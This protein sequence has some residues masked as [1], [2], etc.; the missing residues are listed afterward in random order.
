[1][2][3]YLQINH[4]MNDLHRQCNGCRPPVF[5]LI[6]LDDYGSV[7]NRI[8]LIFNRLISLERMKQ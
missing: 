5:T 2:V 6:C 8:S 7:M 1:M 4:Q 3:E